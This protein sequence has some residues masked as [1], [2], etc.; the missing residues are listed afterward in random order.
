MAKDAGH[1]EAEAD[2]AQPRAV[3]APWAL[4]AD[5]EPI[6]PRTRGE[7]V[8]RP[9]PCPWVACAWHAWHETPV[10]DVDA[11]PE[12][13]VLDVAGEGGA[14]SARVGMVLGITRQ[15]AEQLEA[16]ALSRLHMG[17]RLRLILR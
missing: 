10:D 17:N 13:C 15:G 14:T 6:R 8:G 2:D 3:D 7:C 9:R 5:G 16:R 12:S 1:V 4:D 11:L